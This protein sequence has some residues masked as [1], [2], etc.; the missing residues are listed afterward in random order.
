MFCPQL[1]QAF[2]S[3]L[4]DDL[5]TVYA[6]KALSVNTAQP[7]ERRSSASPLPVSKPS[8]RI[9]PTPR[10]NFST[11]LNSLQKRAFSWTQRDTGNKIISQDSSSRKRKLVG[12]LAPSQKAAWEALAGVPEERPPIGLA[13]LEGYE[14]PAP[15][16]MTE[17]WVLTGDPTKDEAVRASHKYESAPSIILFKVPNKMYNS[18]RLSCIETATPLF[19]HLCDLS[20]I[21]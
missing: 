11:G 9:A 13:S 12:T 1:L 15:M 17:E 19:H 10:S 14:R 6:A 20:I 21:S 4:D 5:V 18:A 7:L 8:A 16:T 2:P 3:L